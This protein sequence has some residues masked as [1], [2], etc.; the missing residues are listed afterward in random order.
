MN[1][2]VFLVIV[3]VVMIN[4]HR[5]PWRLGPRIQHRISTT[6]PRVTLFTIALAPQVSE[7]QPEILQLTCPDEAEYDD[8]YHQWYCCDPENPLIEIHVPDIVHVHAQDAGYST[9]GQKD[10]CDDGE[11]VDG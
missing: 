5:C 8:D 3:V 9:Q 10:N 1:P 2:Q 4:Y 11:G 7:P 6:P